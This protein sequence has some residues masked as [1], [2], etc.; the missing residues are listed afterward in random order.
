MKAFLLSLVLVGTALTQTRAQF[1]DEQIIND[2][3]DDGVAAIAGRLGF[4]YEELG[5]GNNQM[6]HGRRVF[7]VSVPDAG[8]ESGPPTPAERRKQALILTYS[9]SGE[10]VP[11][12]VIHAWNAAWSSHFSAADAEGGTISLNAKLFLV[13]GV[14][15]R[16]VLEHVRRFDQEITAFE[17]SLKH[18]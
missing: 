8:N 11:A 18:H 6:H 13:D 3:G 1:R 7:C 10:N 2:I 5:M 9:A 14:T 4:R 17:A 15:F 12:A 16:T